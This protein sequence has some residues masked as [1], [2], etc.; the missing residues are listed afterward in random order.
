MCG[1]GGES[2]ER[3]V[4]PRGRPGRLVPPGCQGR[5]RRKGSG[6]PEEC[7]GA[8]TYCRPRGNHGLREAD[9]LRLLGGQSHLGGALPVS[10]QGLLGAHRGLRGKRLRLLEGGVLSPPPSYSNL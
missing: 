6:H 3:N 10:Q 9:G 8:S 1:V 2:L 5:G 7:G 4:D